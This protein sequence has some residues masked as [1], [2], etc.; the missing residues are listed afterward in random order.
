MTSKTTTLHLLPIAA[1]CLLAAG[2]ALATNGYF[3][4]GYGIKSKGMGGAAT[5]LAQDSLGG[6]NNPASMVWVGNRFDLGA[7][8]FMPK[9][10]AERSGAGFPTLNGKVDS[11][12]TAFLIPEFGYNRMVGSNLSVGVSVYGNGGLN[13][14]YPQGNFN[15]GGPAANML[16][17]GGGL[18]VDLL[19]LMIA[20][21]VA[22]KLNERHA[23]GVSLLL[24]YQRFKATGLQAF[25]NAPGFPPFTGAPGSVTNNG[26]DDSTGIGLRV[27]YQGRL[28][29]QFTIGAAYA[30]K[31][32]MSRFDKYRGLFA[33]AG[34]FDI[35]S[36]Y[37]IGMAFAPT[38]AWTIAVDAG[39]INY[40]DVPAV[41]NP[42]AAPAPLGASNGPGFGWKDIDVLRLGVAWRMSDALTLRAGYNKGGNPITA[43][44]VT[45][46]ILA[47]GVMKDHYT[48]GFTWALDKDNEIS[49]ALMVAPRQEVSGPSLFNAVLGPGAGGNEKIGMKQ[50]SFGIAWGRRF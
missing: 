2:P 48:A 32:N 41:G 13:T 34:D 23:V 3:S 20:P 35:P 40:S 27:G 37:S 9:R 26:N 14:T 19:Q 33:G 38:P 15:C 42:S 8:V 22:Y 43:A 29:D 18:G 30:P 6:V 11:D 17:G 24:G 12:K 7:D 49:G 50:S 21:T 25:D 16:C 31:M 10:D 4:H 44:D 45:F 28:S 39:R 47:P 36:H 1:A 46:N 5:A